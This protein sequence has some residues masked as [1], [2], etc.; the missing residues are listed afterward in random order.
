MRLLP[1]DERFFELFTR[2]ATLNLH[3]AE[4]LY[5]LIQAEPGRRAH[6]VDAIKRAEHEADEITHEVVTRIDRSFI[7]PLDREDIHMLASR[8]DDV[9]DLIDGTARRTQIFRAEMAP[10]GAVM[11]AEVIVRVTKQLL[12]AVRVLETRKAGPVIAAC[13]QVKKLEEE[14][15]AI[16]HEWLGAL[17]DNGGDPLTVLKWKELYDTLEKTLDQAED[18]ANVLE[19]VAIKHA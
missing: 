10:R 14:G 12:D 4:E 7:T 16:Y 3:A 11:L 2:V 8:L 19:S 18:V 13:I 6:H 9:L 1:R 17:F 5:A 15:D